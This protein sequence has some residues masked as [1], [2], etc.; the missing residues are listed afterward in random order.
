VLTEKEARYEKVLQ[1]LADHGS[2][3]DTNPT[4]RLPRSEEAQ[5]IDSWWLNYVQSL[6]RQIRSRA[7][8]AL[9]PAKYWLVIVPERDAQDQISGWKEVALLPR[10]VQQSE[11]LWTARESFGLEADVRE[12]PLDWTL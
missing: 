11:A 1:D 10:P 7:Q 8:A 5:E 2:R 6:D 3:F 9:R 4:R 12:A